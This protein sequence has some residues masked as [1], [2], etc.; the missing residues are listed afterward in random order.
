MSGVSNPHKPHDALFREMLA[1]RET[2]ISFVREYLPAPVLECL[3]LESLEIGPGS[4]IAPD[5]RAHITDFVGHVHLRDSDDD[6]YL[7][8]LVEHKTTPD[9]LV[10]F[11]LLRYAT[12]LWHAHVTQG[13]GFPLPP[14]IPVVFYHGQ[15]RWTS[16]TEFSAVFRCR[17]ALDPFLPSFRYLLQD[18]TR[19]TDEEIRGI[20]LLR[21]PLRAMRHY[22]AADLLTR[23]PDILRGLDRV[24]DTRPGVDVV[25]T[26]VRY[27]SSSKR[28]SDPEL[29]A[30]VS[31]AF[32]AAGGRRIMA[33]IA[34]RWIERGVQ[35][36][37][38]LGAVTNARRNVLEVL[39]TRFR[40][41][42]RVLQSRI[43]RIEDVALLGKL[44]KAAIT[45][46]SLQAFEQELD[47]SPS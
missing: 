39:R 3:D 30:A 7:Y 4:I 16:S 45:T 2:A 9:R 11:Q 18:L 24:T 29:Q 36:G 25:A 43:D 31:E 28:V 46:T 41:V 22:Y 14:V 38:Q 26:V 35:Q 15:R 13:R 42:P 8:L 5:L 17:A 27:L 12:Q 19:Y 1:R 23:V 32:G 34:D 33:T 44:L 37:I 6:A 40:R 47:S 10:A 20:E 21:A